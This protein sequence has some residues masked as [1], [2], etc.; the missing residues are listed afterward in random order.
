MKLVPIIVF[1]VTIAEP[2]SSYE[3][4]TD[5][6]LEVES[7]VALPPD[8]GLNGDADLLGYDVDGGGV[9]DDIQRYL[10]LRYFE[11]PKLKAVFYDYA[12]A[13]LKRISSASQSEEY[14]QNLVKEREPSYLCLMGLNNNS[15]R[16]YRSE[17]RELKQRVFNTA[18]RYKANMLF[19]SKLAG[20]VMTAIDI[21]AYKSYCA[22]YGLDN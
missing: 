14:I 2:A 17:I 1:L 20:T 16:D 9:R 6:I 10:E 21:D 22:P 7:Q 8:P 13:L 4:T 3:I 11:E 5:R 19:D 15:E 18:A 12:S